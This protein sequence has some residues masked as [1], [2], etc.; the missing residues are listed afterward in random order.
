MPINDKLVAYHINRLKDRNP[1]VRLKTIH[2]L[3]LIGDQT[4][5][6]ALEALYNN[7]RDPVVRKAAQEA[8]R[9]LF[10]RLRSQK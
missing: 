5:L 7:E 1:E 10:L 9:T 4:A 2:E 6:E 3:T 8:G